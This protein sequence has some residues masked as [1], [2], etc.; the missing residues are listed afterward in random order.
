MKKL[1]TIALMLLL[2]ST[3]FA[4]TRVTGKVTSA[5]DGQPIPFASVVVKGTMTGV[6]SNENGV[7][8]LPS[9]PAN[10]TLVFSSIGFN[11]LEV[12]VAGR[13][14]IDAAMAPNAESLEETIVV[15]Y[16]TAK[17]GTYTGAASVVRQDAIKDVPSVSFEQ[18][19]N[20][21]V[22]GMQITQS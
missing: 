8:V 13:T 15:A 21:K 12:Q 18:A 6:A 5:Q 14:V 3:A 11:D 16:G 20:G 2:C 22:A 17:K 7:Y 9:V 4:Q 1:L 10:A 19:L